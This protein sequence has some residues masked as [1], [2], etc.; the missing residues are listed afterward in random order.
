V[1]HNTFVNDRPG[2]RP[3]DRCPHPHRLR[4]RSGHRDGERPRPY[5]QAH[6]GHV[7]HGIGNLED[8][9]RMSLV[10]KPTTAGRRTLRKRKRL[11]LTVA[12]RFKPAGGAAVTR[13]SK[14]ILK[15]TKAGVRGG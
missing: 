13:A 9:G 3:R 8:R 11:S 6:E 10:L 1:V 14:V 7:R 4:S 15:R 2:G 5:Q 12:V